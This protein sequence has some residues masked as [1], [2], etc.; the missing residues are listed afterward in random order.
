MGHSTRPVLPWI[1]R[2]YDVWLIAKLT[3]IFPS[4]DAP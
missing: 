1:E 2:N 3:G 4:L